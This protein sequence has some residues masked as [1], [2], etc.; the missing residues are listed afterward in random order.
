M[1]QGSSVVCNVYL[2]CNHERNNSFRELAVLW[3]GYGVA[4]V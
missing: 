4:I 2:C 3:L 1:R